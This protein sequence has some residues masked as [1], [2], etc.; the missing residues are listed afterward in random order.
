MLPN[1]L[2]V[3]VI[4]N[5]RLPLISAQLIIPGAGSATDPPD[6]MGLAALT[7]DLLDEGTGTLGPMQVAAELERL[8]AYLQTAADTDVASISVNSLASTLPDTL[9]LVA[10]LVRSPSLSQADFDRI[11]ADRLSAIRRRRDN[12][13]A[14][15]SLVIDRVLYGAHPYAHP[16]AGYERT[17]SAIRLADVR[18]YYRARYTP[19]GATLVVAGD[20]TAADVNAIAAKAFGGWKKHTAPAAPMPAPDT[21]ARPRL[22]VVDKPGAPQSV[23]EIGRVSITRTAPT[24]FAGRVANTVVGGGFTS[25]LNRRLREQL[26]YTYG[27]GSRFWMGARSGTWTAHS[28]LRTDVTVAGLR[29][30]LALIQSMRTADVPPDEL[31]RG[32][33]LLVRELPGEFETNGRIAGSFAELASENVAL[34]WYRGFTRGVRG[35]TAA[36]VRTFARDQWAPESLVVVVVGDLSKVMDGLLDLG[37]GAALELSPEGDTVRTHPAH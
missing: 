34:D 36:E 22:V 37:L 16:G 35:V 31:H 17:L 9:L 21:A 19:T 23:V 18:E 3:V 10:N 26:G 5:H 30:A 7:A 8:G 13:R 28:S 32:Q 1:G 12:P 2:R 33:E 11:K 6:H 27:A 14:V 29:E 20:I 4:E 15:A 25:R 24:Y